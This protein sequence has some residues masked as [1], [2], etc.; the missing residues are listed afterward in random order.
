MLHLP[1][2]QVVTGLVI[3]FLGFSNAWAASFS[4]SPVIAHLT[5]EQTITS[6]TIKNQAAT[7]TAI[8]LQLFRW[9]QIDGEE[10]LTPAPELL[11]TPT[12][13]KVPGNASQIIRVGMRQPITTEQE[14]AYRLILKEIPSL[15]KPGFQGLNVLL[16]ISI[17]IFVSKSM[18]SPMLDWRASVNSDGK[19]IL[20]SNNT[21][22]GHTKLLHVSLQ[23]DSQ[24][25]PLN[26]YRQVYVLA[27]D[28]LRWTTDLTVKPGME[29]LLV[30]NTS[31][32][33][34][35]TRLRVE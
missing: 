33:R 17:P 21:G 15:P 24:P 9:Q 25:T 1:S 10:R 2:N 28:H 32:G 6:F 16:R 4:V 29:I 26:L 8:E 23:G 11:V 12:I 19:L 5:E 34:V 31:K 30:A 35:T 22:S 7:Q 14:Q 27:G 3:F 18:T 20:E 13:F